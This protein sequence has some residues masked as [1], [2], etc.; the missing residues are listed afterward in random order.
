MKKLIIILFLFI[1]ASATSSCKWVINTGSIGIEEIIDSLDREEVFGEVIRSDNF[2][3]DLQE[4]YDFYDNIYLFQYMLDD[5]NFTFLGGTGDDEYQSYFDSLSNT[6]IGDFAEID[7]LISQGNIEEA[8]DLNESLPEDKEFYLN[9]KQANRIFFRSFALGDYELTEADSTELMDIALQL[10][11][12]GGDGV[13]VARAMLGID[14]DDYGVSYRKPRPDLDTSTPLSTSVKVYPNP[15]Q[16]SIIVEFT[17]ETELLNAKIEFFDIIGKNV[18]EINLNGESN[19]ETVSIS[20]LKNGIY[21]IKISN[22][23]TYIDIFKIIKL[24]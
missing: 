14:P 22:K 19:I 12:P 24:Q 3:N 4:V 17:Q 8:I 7:S 21:F 11:Y 6:S 9:R 1:A 10:P 18:R 13:Y 2:Y 20:G 15:A 5:E 23:N 16:N